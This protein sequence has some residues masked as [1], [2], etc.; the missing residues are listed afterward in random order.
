M[1]IRIGN[2]VWASLALLVFVMAEAG[3]HSALSASPARSHHGPITLLEVLFDVVVLVWFAGAVTLFLRKVPARIGWTSS[4]VGV[5]AAICFFSAG[6]VTLVWVSLEPNS[7]DN[8]RLSEL[9]VGAAERAF[10]SMTAIIMFCIPLGISVLL[11]IGLLLKRRELLGS[12]PPAPPMI[13]G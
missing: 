1:F 10:T 7:P 6:V 2:M 11:C 8:V 4:L 9:G 12:A 3:C 13:G 5:V